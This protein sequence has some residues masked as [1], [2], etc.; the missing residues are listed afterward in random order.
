MQK[1]DEKTIVNSF[2]E[3]FNKLINLGHVDENNIVKNA[4]SGMKNS[5]DR[6]IN[7]I[8][9]NY[10]KENN[11]PINY[12]LDK[13]YFNGGVYVY[14]INVDDYKRIFKTN[15][16]Q[17]KFCP[18]YENKILQGL[19]CYNCKNSFSCDFYNYIL[20]NKF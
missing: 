7:L 6:E 17:P 16:M 2:I 5:H 14:S 4:G 10:I 9:Q 3:G 19:T 15:N 12:V 11:L 20:Q 13:D 8:F 1:L 18:Y